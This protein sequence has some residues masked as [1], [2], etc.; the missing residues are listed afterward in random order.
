MFEGDDL[1]A[2]ERRVDEWETGLSERAA[3]AR[4]LATRLADLS[5]SAKSSDGLVTVRVSA[6]GMAGLELAEGIRQRPAT[7][8][9]EAIMATLRK[10]QEALTVAATRVTEETVGADSETGKAV[11]AAYRARHG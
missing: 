7:E 5:V 10:A 6:S 11:I 8:T 4:E 9:A 3:A 1:D 2:A